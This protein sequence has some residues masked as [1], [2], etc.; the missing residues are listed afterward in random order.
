V[1]SVPYVCDAEPGVKTYLDLP[2]IAGR[3]TS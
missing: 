3:A 2:M 1:N